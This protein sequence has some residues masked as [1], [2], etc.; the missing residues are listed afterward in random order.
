[1][2]NR[3]AY[4][5]EID[6]EEI[7]QIFR[8]MEEAKRKIWDCVNKLNRACAIKLTGAIKEDSPEDGSDI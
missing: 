1:M 2:E 5:L 4:Y 7:N 6:A 3:Y 8:E